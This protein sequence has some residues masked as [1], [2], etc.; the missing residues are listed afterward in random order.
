[1][2]IQMTHYIF[3]YDKLNEA[4]NIYQQKYNDAVACM[5]KSLT[6][7]ERFV[8]SRQAKMYKKMRDMLFH[9]EQ[10]DRWVAKHEGDA[11]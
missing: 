2:A 6:C 3:D 1:M 8:W 11:T 10:A 4:V 5:K 9:P 7:D